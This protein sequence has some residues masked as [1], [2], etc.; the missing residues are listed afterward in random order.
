MSNL[1]WVDPRVA[2]VRVAALRSYLSTRGWKAKPYPGPELL[3][4]EGPPDDDGEP[5]IQVVPS[6]EQML[7]F[8]LRVTELIEALSVLEGRPAADILA[9]IL[10]EGPGHPGPGGA[11]PSPGPVPAPTH[12]TDPG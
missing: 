2:S 6:S 11:L 8:H 12:P 4:F 9:D 5:I 3:V 10:R 1:A 7:D